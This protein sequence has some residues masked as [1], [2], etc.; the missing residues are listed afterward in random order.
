MRVGVLDRPRVGAVFERLDGARLLLVSAPA[1]SG[2]TVAVASLGCL[3][4]CCAKLV[5]LRRLSKAS[6]P[7]AR[8]VVVAWWQGGR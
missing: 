5:Q 6:A 1:G 7:S 4:G 3:G 2:K 8:D